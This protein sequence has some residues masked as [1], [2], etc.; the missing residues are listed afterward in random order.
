MCWDLERAA[1]WS[2]GLSKARQDVVIPQEGAKE[3]IWEA[4]SPSLSLLSLPGGRVQ[5]L[6]L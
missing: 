6:L 5:S 3:G 2:C 4:P 1:H